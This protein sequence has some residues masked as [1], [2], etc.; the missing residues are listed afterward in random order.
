MNL[1]VGQPAP[2]FML[3]DQDGIMHSLKEYR[4]MWVLLYFYP[5]DNTTGCTKEACA[6]RNDFP[7]FGERGAKVLGVSIDSVG[8]HK[9]FAEKYA[10]PFTLLADEE[11]RVVEQYG[12]WEKKQFI[13]KE[14]MG[15]MRTSFLIDPEGKIAKIYEKVQP[16]IHAQE[17]LQDLRKFTTRN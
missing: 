12:V 14:Y 2:E 9:K 3:P 17:V 1:K 5:K 10:L 6:I 7:N 13:G 16:E 8:S 11:K 4:G 15:T